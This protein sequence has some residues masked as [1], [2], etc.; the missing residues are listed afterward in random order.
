MYPEDGARGEGGGAMDCAAVT[1]PFAK[2]FSY[3]TAFKLRKEEIEEN[4]T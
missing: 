1:S 3:Q 4:M 2:L